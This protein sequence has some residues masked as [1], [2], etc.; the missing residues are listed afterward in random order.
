MIPAGVTATATRLW[1]RARRPLTT[2]RALYVALNRRR[3]GRRDLMVRSDSV[4]LIEGPMRSG[5]TFAVAAFWHANG[6]HHHVGRH[7]H[8]AAHVMEAHR[9]GVP[10]IVTLRDPRDSCVS[11]VIRRPAL[12]L[13][14][15][16]DDYVL[17]Y[18]AIEDLR[19]HVTVAPFAEI[20]SDFGAVL[21][22]LNERAGTDFEAYIATPEHDA[23]V[24]LMTEQMNRAERSSGGAVDEMRVSRPSPQRAAEADRVRRAFDDAGNAP[25]LA[26]AVQV[27]DEWR[28]GS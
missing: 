1:H 10:I 6:A 11:H 20:T 15:A 21:R 9:L 17:F 14:D 3:P 13:R 16:L 25:L 27:Y 26:A 22:R 28:V 23:Q 7:L 18:R 19:D 8:A 12:T 2:H 24:I 5:N 4:V